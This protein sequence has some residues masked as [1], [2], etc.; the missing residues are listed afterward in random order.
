MMQKRSRVFIIALFFSM[1]LW[2]CVGN[3]IV[4]DDDETLLEDGVPVSITA[5]SGGDSSLKILF[6]EADT[7]VRSGKYSQR[8]YGTKTTVH[9]DLDDHDT[10]KLGL[11]RF[12][13]GDVGSIAKAVLTLYVV[14]GS[15]DSMDIV[16]ISDTTWNESK[17]T[18]E[19]KPQTT[20]INLASIRSTAVS[21]WI[22]V[23]VTSAVSTNGILS[24]AFLGRSSNGIDVSSREAA[25]HQP[26]LELTL[27][28]TPH[29]DAGIP[30]VDTMPVDPTPS[31]ALHRFWVN[32]NH[33]DLLFAGIKGA[34]SPS[35]EVL[36]SWE[37][38][39]RAIDEWIERDSGARVHRYRATTAT[40]F[41]D[42]WFIAMNRLLASMEWLHRSR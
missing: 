35:S 33:Y 16:A 3:L 6:P 4:E 42:R 18:W 34:K 14:N 28:N 21:S 1:A 10:V 31:V 37:S 23:D 7:F 12:R 19:T 11:M 41:G 24:L 29:T 13:I 39:T 32:W 20:G 27:A 40:I 38:A 36:E 26:K 5:F 25:S 2:G 22:Q 9:M 15:S 30:V 17:V 8:N